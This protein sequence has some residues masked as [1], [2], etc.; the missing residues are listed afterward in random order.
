MHL[1][2][3]GGNAH[4]GSDLV[5]WLSGDWKKYWGNDS[6]EKMER[7]VTTFYIFLVIY[8]LVWC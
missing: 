6:Y 2:F 7:F 3:Q 4:C 1:P 5:L 8:W